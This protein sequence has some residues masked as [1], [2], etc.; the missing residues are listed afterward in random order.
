MISFTTNYDLI[1]IFKRCTNS[2]ANSLVQHDLDRVYLKPY[3]FVQGILKMQFCTDRLQS[4]I[5]CVGFK[6]IFENH[7][8][9]YIR[10]T[11]LEIQNVHK[12]KSQMNNMSVSSTVVQY[13]V[14]AWDHVIFR[15]HVFLSHEIQQRA[16]I[17]YLEIQMFD[18]Q[19]TKSSDK[20]K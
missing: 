2:A 1:K 18:T 11:H 3:M 13:T 15:H 20:N 10:Y 8:H 16:Y 14:S 4:L 7:I 5:T 9:T 12:R 17:L 19:K 6:E